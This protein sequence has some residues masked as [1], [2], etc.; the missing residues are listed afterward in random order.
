MTQWKMTVGWWALIRY[1]L[2]KLFVMDQ[3]STHP[4]AHSEG[5]VTIVCGTCVMT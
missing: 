1:S 3:G 2:R 4:I 5:L